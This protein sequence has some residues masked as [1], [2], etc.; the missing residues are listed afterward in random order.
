ME[1]SVAC[2]AMLVHSLTSGDRT[3]LEASATCSCVPLPRR[4]RE[5]LRPVDSS[6]RYFSLILM[7]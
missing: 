6:P 3:V 7:V 4:V 1:Y 5:T 2:W